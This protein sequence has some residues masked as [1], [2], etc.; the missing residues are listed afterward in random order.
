MQALTV[1]ILPEVAGVEYAPH[2]ARPLTDEALGSVAG[3]LHDVPWAASPRAAWANPARGH[4]VADLALARTAHWSVP[5]PIGTD[6]SR[7]S[8]GPLRALLKNSAVVLPGRE[9]H[10]QHFSLRKVRHH[11]QQLWH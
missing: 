5:D 7:H 8:P 1:V 11:A 3:P 9:Q 6:G 4:V 2:V 10:V